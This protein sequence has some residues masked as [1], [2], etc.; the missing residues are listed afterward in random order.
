MR[1]HLDDPAS[2][3]Y[4]FDIR[5]PGEFAEAHYTAAVSAPGGQL[6][7]ATDDFV[8]VRK[9]R[10]IL[11]DTPD[12]VRAAN[13][14]QW[15]RLLHD[16]PLAV[17]VFDPA[18]DVVRPERVTP[19]VPDTRRVSWKTL[20]QWQSEGA[21]TVADVRPSAR[22]TAAHLPGSVHARRE[23]LDELAADGG[24]IVLVGDD[25]F[26]AEHLAD[27]RIGD[28]WVLDGG[29]AAAEQ[30][31]V[32]TDARYAGKVVDRTGAPEFGPERDAWYRA[33]FAWELALLDE[34]DGD[35]FFDFA[36]AAG[37]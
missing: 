21:V 7:Q 9:S 5:S 29:I 25:D 23:H 24:R 34:T 35:P 28:I 12:R 30:D 20:V 32:T 10:L 11:V 3:T 26:A 33:Y 22:Y 36:A 37:T 17:T 31:L 6:V 13:T 2:T 27:P 19:A 8:A 1:R 15:L 18:T 4:L 16:G 14:V